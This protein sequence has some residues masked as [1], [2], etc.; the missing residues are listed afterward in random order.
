MKGRKN[1]HV[2]ITPE[3]YLYNGKD[4]KLHMYI[5]PQQ[6]INENGKR[7]KKNRASKW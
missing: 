2:L 1:P 7:G 5:S 4:S 6:K 3:L